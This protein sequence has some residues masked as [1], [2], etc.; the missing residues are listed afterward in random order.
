MISSMVL[1]EDHH[2]WKVITWLVGFSPGFSSNFRMSEGNLVGILGQVAS[3]KMGSFMSLVKSRMLKDA[4][5]GTGG[6]C[7]GLVQVI[8]CVGNGPIP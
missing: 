6:F 1:F 3:C 4:K 8:M 7:E 2:K 5:Y